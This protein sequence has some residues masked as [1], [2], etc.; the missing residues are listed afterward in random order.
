[1]N[2]SSHY[3]DSLMIDANIAVWA[4]WFLW[5]LKFRHLIVFNSGMSNNDSYFLPILGTMAMFLRVEFV[6]KMVGTIWIL[7]GSSVSKVVVPTAIA[8][9]A[10]ES[11]STSKNLTYNAWICSARKV[12]RS[13]SDSSNV[14]RQ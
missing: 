2:I 14:V 3:S 6:I 13:S 9:F 4:A 10:T 11:Q 12:A 1:M 5:L 8:S 7:S